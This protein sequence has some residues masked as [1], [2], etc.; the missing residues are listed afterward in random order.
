MEA[1]SELLSQ[2]GKDAAS[3]RSVSAAAGVQAPTIYR[4]FGD[5][6]GLLGAVARE[7]FA[8]YVRDMASRDTINSDPLE[9][10]R[11]G[12]DQHIAF[13]LANPAV[14]TLIYGDSSAANAPAARDAH[15]ILHTLVTRVAQAGQL[16][17]SVEHAVSMLIAAGSGAALFLI[18]AAP[19][20]R[21]ASLSHDLREAVL[22]AITTAPD[23]NASPSEATRVPARAIAL[24]AVLDETADVLSFAE[25]ALMSEWL[26]RL[27]VAGSL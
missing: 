11:R 3:T 8:H 10:L 7:T 15:A 14:Y 6:Q 4:K 9:S 2:G 24:H 5:M 21:N 27:S 23:E 19:E 26:E 17:V 12:W 18:A 16:R 22:S 13:A 20:A 25:R 1:A